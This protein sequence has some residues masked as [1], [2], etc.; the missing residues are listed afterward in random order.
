MP[1]PQGFR[2]HQ[3]DDDG[4]EAQQTETHQDVDVQHGEV[5]QL[6]KAWSGLLKTTVVALMREDG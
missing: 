3:G 6:G 2:G 5:A 4:R 1:V